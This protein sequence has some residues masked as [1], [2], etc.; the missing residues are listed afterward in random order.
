LLYNCTQCVILPWFKESNKEACTPFKP[1]ALKTID[2]LPF[3]FE[4]TGKKE[5]GATLL[6]ARGNEEDITNYILQ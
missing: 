4:K 3:V 5:R 2:F 1:Y 6:L